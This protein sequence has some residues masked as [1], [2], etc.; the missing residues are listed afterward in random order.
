MI[1]S[2]KNYAVSETDTAHKFK[3]GELF[4]GAG[5]TALGAHMAQISGF[6]FE[7]AGVNDKDSDA[8]KTL[9]RN[10]PIHPDFVFDCDVSELS[11]DR[12]PDID[13]FVFGFP[14][15][16]FSVVGDR[17]GIAGH[18]GGLYRWGIQILEK[19]KPLFFLAENVSGLTS[20][21]DDF[22]IIKNDLIN[23]GY[24]IFPR[25]YKFEQ[26]GVP[27]N[28]QRIIVVGF[29]DDLDIFNFN[30]PEPTTLNNPVTVMQALSG[31]KVDAANNEFTNQS[32]TVIERLK[33]IK[34]GENAFTADLPD[35]L[36]LKLKSGATISQIYKRLE[37]D[38]PSY[39]VTGSGGGGTHI[40]HWQENRALTNR[41]RA[42]LQA[43]PDGF[44]FEGGKESVRRQIGMSVPPLGAQIIF[45]GILR[46]L[47]NHKV[48]SQC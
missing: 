18:Y 6:G 12:L 28:R 2:T 7:H 35:H 44:I 11:L 40:Y 23:S 17:H 10:I 25:L 4:A 15:N 5:G 31:I 27:Q 41:E 43:F 46:T 32:T 33:H 34:P 24:K 37:P 26:Y 1:H 8:C 29:R 47:I 14:C 45:E 39:T 36:K 22:E 20:S 3:L 21:G 16:D 38:K 9:A 42:R 48:V 30:H 19:Y 13:G